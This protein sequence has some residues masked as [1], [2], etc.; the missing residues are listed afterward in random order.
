MVDGDIPCLGM[1]YESMDQCKESIQKELNNEEEEYMQ[2]WETIDC[3]WKMMHAPLH[4]TSCFLEP[5]LFVI[6]RRGD[7][8]IKAGLYQAISRY[9]PDLEIAALIKD[10]SWQYKRGEGMF[11]GPEAKYDSPPKTTSL[12]QTI[13]GIAMPD[14]N[15]P[16]FSDDE[17]SNDTNNDDL[18]SQPSA[19]DDL[20]LF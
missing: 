8:E 9:A 10:Q 6:D 17:L 19:L 14:A 7:N 4:V 11:G 3:R 16:N 1:L 12:E 18:A 20:E 5:K 2:I 15:E 13:E